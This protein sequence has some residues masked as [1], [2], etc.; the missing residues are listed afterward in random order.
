MWWYELF[1]VFGGAISVIVTRNPWSESIIGC[2]RNIHIFES[3]ELLFKYL[4]ELDVLNKTVYDKD[5][6]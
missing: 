3:Y 5:P 1:Y 2:C 4:F 6:P